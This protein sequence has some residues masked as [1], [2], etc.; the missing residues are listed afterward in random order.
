MAGGAP[1]SAAAGGAM[2]SCEHKFKWQQTLHSDGVLLFQDVLLP[3]LAGLDHLV[4]W[5]L[6]ISSCRD[7]DQMQIVVVPGDVIPSVPDPSVE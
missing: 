3:V 5:H 4:P 2:A 1:S 7:L 6:A